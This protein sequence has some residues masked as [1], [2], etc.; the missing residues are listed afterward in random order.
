MMTLSLAILSLCLVILTGSMIALCFHRLRLKAKWAASASASGFIVSLLL[1]GLSFGGEGQQGPKL[2]SPVAPC[3][4]QVDVTN[5]TGERSTA[6]VAK[7]REVEDEAQQRVEAA[8]AEE[9]EARQRAEAARAEE[10][11]ARQRAEAAKA[12]EIEARQHADAAKAEA[13]AANRKPRT[14]IIIRGGR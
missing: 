5:S 14:P 2:G 9:A 4:E 10:I 7:G 8:R 11:E 13:E 1:L 6:G 12:E 3:A